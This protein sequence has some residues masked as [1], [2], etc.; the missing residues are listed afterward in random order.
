MS[1]RQGGPADSGAEHAVGGAEAE[2]GRSPWAS[3]GGVDD[4]G[5]AEFV[6][7]VGVVR[8]AIAVALRRMRVEIEQA[9][10]VDDQSEPS[11]GFGQRGTDGVDGGLDEGVKRD[12][13]VS[14]EAGHG[15]CSG[16]GSGRAREGGEPRDQ[17][18]DGVCVFAHEFPEPNLVTAVQEAEM[19]A[20]PT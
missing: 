5:G 4:Q 7:G 1:R 15:A 11:G 20:M 2:F 14:E 6:A 18:V 3:V 8:P 9:P 10:V 12:L 16:H 19:I 13:I 17:R